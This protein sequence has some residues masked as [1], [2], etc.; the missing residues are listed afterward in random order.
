VSQLPPSEGFWS[1]VERGA[2]DDCWPWT[3]GLV[4]GY[5]Q[6]SVGGHKQ[7]YAHRVAWE[8]T[9]G[10]IPAGLTIDHT[11]HNR[12]ACAGGKTCP[13]RRCCNPRHLDPVPQRINQARSPNHGSR[14]THCRRGG[15]PLSGDNL[16]TTPAGLRQCK[17]CRRETQRRHDRKRRP[18]R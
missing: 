12:S 13:H 7:A 11:C 17:T 14:L 2:P 18:R 15:H 10:S 3:R 9:N 6:L 8:L 5:G 16:Y 4:G 1:R